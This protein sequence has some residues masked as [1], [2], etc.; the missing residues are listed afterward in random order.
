[1]QENTQFY[2]ILE[3]YLKKFKSDN[4]SILCSVSKPWYY[5]HL[6]LNIPGGEG[7][8]RSIP[9][10]YLPDATSALPSQVWWPHMS[11]ALPSVPRG[12]EGESHWT[13]RKFMSEIL[14]LSSCFH[15]VQIMNCPKNFDNDSRIPSAL[16]LFSSKFKRSSQEMAKY[17]RT[18]TSF[19]SPA[20]PSY[21]YV[22]L[23]SGVHWMC[24]L[25]RMRHLN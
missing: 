10:L 22:F 6:G 11:Q 8:L 2:K 1:M 20:C 14:L 9:G 5:W 19:I 16:F 23:C 24:C 15:S 21:A 25:W 17:A 7:A 3:G 13:V 18:V 12:S 4:L